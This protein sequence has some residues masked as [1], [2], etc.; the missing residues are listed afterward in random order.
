MTGNINEVKKGQKLTA[1]K[2]NQIIGKLNSISGS[3]STDQL[4]RIDVGSFELFGIRDNKIKNGKVETTVKE[5]RIIN[6]NWSDGGK[7]TNTIPDR[8]LKDDEL[9]GLTSIWFVRLKE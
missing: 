9:D 3:Y 8:I 2:V 5:I 1:H 6:N 7:D 4:N